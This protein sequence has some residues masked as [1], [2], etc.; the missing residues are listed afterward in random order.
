MKVQQQISCV[1]LALAGIAAA[2]SPGAVPTVESIVERMAQARAN[3][4]ARLRPYVVTRD[5]VLFG[6]EKH[7]TKSEVTAQLTF[8]PPNS[9]EYKILRRTGSGLGERLVRRMLDGE[10]TIV[11]EYGLTDI[12]LQNYEFEFSGEESVNGRHCYVLEIRPRRNDKTLI[13][14]TIWVDA[15]TYLLHRMEGEPAQ[16]P[17]WWLQNAR[18]TFLYSDV[19]GM[20]L[21][22]ASEFSTDVR[23]FG[24]HTM[25]SRDVQWETR[26]E[27][28]AAGRL[29]TKSRTQSNNPLLGAPEHEITQNQPLVKG[30]VT[31]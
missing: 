4:R 11:K 5:Y 23:I 21:Q 19:E 7:T 17:S 8:F 3:N 13:H 9:K 24:E 31:P 14:G 22:T 2:Q 29:A 20:W 1:F 10:T 6:K 16:N 30:D 27:Q 15:D 18:I 12:S 26:G 25:I 28:D